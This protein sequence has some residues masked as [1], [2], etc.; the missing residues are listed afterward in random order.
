MYIYIYIYIYV[1]LKRK[2]LRSIKVSNGLH[3]I[4]GHQI[5]NF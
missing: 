2:N 5:F 3:N 4:N 1:Q